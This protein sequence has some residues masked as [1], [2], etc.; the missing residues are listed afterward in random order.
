MATQKASSE[1]KKSTAEKKVANEK[2]VAEKAEPKKGGSTNWTP[3]LIIIA[4]I[5]IA[6]VLGYF[7]SSALKGTG[8]GQQSFQSFQSS[9]Y[10]APRVGIYVTYVNGTE[11]SYVSGC[12]Y[13][14][15]ERIIASSNH[16]RNAST[17]DFMVVANSTSCLSPNGAL[18][19]SN[20]TKVTPISNC[21]AISKTEPSVFIN[22][23]LA[24][25]TVIRSQDLYTSGDSLFLSECGIASE[26]G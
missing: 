23:S 8:T 13:Q 9:F 14:V 1:K 3:A 2:K 25:S 19:S 24:N 16:H 11:F 22:Y 5:A 21:L 6:A 12:A 15:I 17:I 26:L 4:V 20:G 18:G 7:A 10:T